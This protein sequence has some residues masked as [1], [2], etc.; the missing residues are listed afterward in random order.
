MN[1]R[2][3]VVIVERQ[4]QTAGAESEKSQ[5]FIKVSKLGNHLIPKTHT[6]ADIHFL[7]DSESHL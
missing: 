5:A 7:L 1:R 2:A 6:L 4:A 3:S